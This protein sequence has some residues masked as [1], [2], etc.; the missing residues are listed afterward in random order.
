[1][2]SDLANYHGAAE[3]DRGLDIL[4]FGLTATLTPPDGRSRG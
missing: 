3:L 2:A 4:L 1:L